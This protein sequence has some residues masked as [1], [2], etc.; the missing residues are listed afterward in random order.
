MKNKP[1][2]SISRLIAMIFAVTIL[3]TLLSGCSLLGDGATP[4]AVIPLEQSIEEE[5]TVVSEGNLVPNDFDYL[6]FAKGGRVAE[7]LVSKGDT[8]AEGQVLARIADR[9]QA[10]ASLAG[11]QLENLSAQQAYDELVRTAELARSA[12]WLEL[13][14]AKEALQDR[15]QQWDEIDTESFRNQIDD[16]ELAVTNAVEDVQDAQEEFDKYQNLDEDN[17]SRQRAEDEL[18]NAEDRLT[19]AEQKRDDLI[20]QRDTARAG[21]DQ[22]Q[23]ALVE[24]QRKYDLTAN[25]PD[26]EKLAL[27]QARLNNSQAQITAAQAGLDYLEL[28]APYAGTIVDVNISTN[29]QVG[30][31]RWAFLIADFSS[32][33]VETNDLTELEVVRI[34]E[35]QSAELVA[36]ALPE[37]QSI[38]VVEE[39]SQ[40]FTTQAGDILYKV[41][42]KVDEIDPRMRWGM[43]FEVTFIP[44]D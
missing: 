30:T 29:Q 17:P 42:I 1:T 37:V 5:F 44:E 40:S 22:A 18:E 43:T 21:L 38:G 41:R 31:E 6:T 27:A 9:E 3:G 28:K 26:T 35:G 2:L 16:A 39:I 32:W 11:A 14:R 20:Y 23:A 10:E 13:I 25:G 34:S 36:D 15:Q 7:I 19:D 12:A 24:T 8:V 4:E 33:Y